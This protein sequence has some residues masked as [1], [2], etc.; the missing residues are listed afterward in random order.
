MQSEIHLLLGDFVSSFELARQAIVQSDGNPIAVGRLYT[1]IAR[2]CEQ[3][4]E[5]DSSFSYLARAIIILEREGDIWALGRTQ[6]NMGALLIHMGNS[7]EAYDMLSKAEN[8]QVLLGDRVG[9]ES[10]R[11]NF[12]VLR[13]RFGG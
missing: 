13:A 1:L 9:L 10:T 7:Y 6:S 8:S 4:G 11:H 12:R 5:V 3:Q 2:I